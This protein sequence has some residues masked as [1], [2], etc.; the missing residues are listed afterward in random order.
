MT[1]KLTSVFLS[2]DIPKLGK[3]NSIV[4]VTYG[5]ARNYLIP[6]NLACLV[7]EGVIKQ[8]KLFQKIKENKLKNEKQEA[9]LIKNTLDNI[10]HLT[11][12]KKTG[13][14]NTIFGSVTNREI[15]K[16]LSKNF[17]IELNKISIDNISDIKKIGNYNITI[18]LNNLVNTNIQLRILPE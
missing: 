2:K 18:R 6:S 17:N 8:Q 10:D 5:Y 4:K 15:I 14:Q 1:K 9:L 11:I 12:K 16:I 3:A 13:D 7:N